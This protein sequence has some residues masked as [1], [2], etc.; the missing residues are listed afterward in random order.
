RRG[1]KICS[2]ERVVVVSS[3]PRLR[4]RTRRPL[5]RHDGLQIDLP[6]LGKPFGFAVDRL[7]L[8]AKG[9]KPSEVYQAP[10]GS[11]V[12]VGL[13]AEHPAIP[14]GAPVY[15]SSSQAVKQKYRHERPKPGLWHG[16]KPLV[17]DAVLTQARL[18]VTA[19]SGSAEVQREL[20][21]PFAKAQDLAA[22]E[23]A[24][25]GCFARLGQ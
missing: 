16:R 5:E 8:A 13:P 18:G 22:I 23:N 4:F 24:V 19:R 9:K 2:V 3:Q 6:V 10:A 1:T 15:C 14:G 7:W 21:G 11:W 12:E 25:R 17:I 20:L